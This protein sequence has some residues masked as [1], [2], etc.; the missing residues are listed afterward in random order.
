MRFQKLTCSIFFN[1]QSNLI[2]QHLFRHLISIQS[3][4]LIFIG[5]GN[6]K[7]GLISF[8]VL[9]L[10]QIDFSYKTSSI[11]LFWAAIPLSGPLRATLVDILVNCEEITEK[12]LDSEK[13]GKSNA[14]NFC[15]GWNNS[16]VNGSLAINRRAFQS[17]GFRTT[18]L[19]SAKQV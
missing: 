18:F 8:F 10:Y 6:Q 3:S 9:V 16:F 13:D 12:S 14:R 2:V 5:Q 15:G 4:C 19:M 11:Y 1:V 7:K 17:T